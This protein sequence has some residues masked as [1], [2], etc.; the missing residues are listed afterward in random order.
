M[1]KSNFLP[2]RPLPLQK[3]HL[4][5]DKHARCI[6][7][8]LRFHRRKIRENPPSKKHV[9]QRTIPRNERFPRFF[10]A[11]KCR[12]RDRRHQT[13]LCQH[14]PRHALRFSNVA[15]F[16]RFARHPQ[17]HT[18]QRFDRVVHGKN[19]K[20]NGDQWLDGDGGGNVFTFVF[21]AREWVW[22]VDGFVFVQ[23]DQYCCMVCNYCFSVWGLRD[24]KKVS[25]VMIHGL[26]K[27]TTNG[28]F[29][30]KNGVFYLTFSNRK[31][32]G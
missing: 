25:K 18:R 31:M 14:R 5:L 2:F 7:R 15:L 6:L 24:R 29:F 28:G 4:H 20:N 27:M 11:E 17:C 22:L 23:C 19:W 12:T 13:M 32:V 8:I 26:I 30:N 3:L 21:C 1:T 16:N 9:Q 10:N